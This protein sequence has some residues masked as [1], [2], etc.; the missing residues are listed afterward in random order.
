MATSSTSHHLHA[1]SLTVKSPDVGT[2]SLDNFY[3]VEKFEARCRAYAIQFF[4][5]GIAKADAVDMLQ[6]GA[7]AMGL[8]DRRGQDTIQA[9]MASVFAK[10]PPRPLPS[11]P[12]DYTGLDRTFALACQRADTKHALKGERPKLGWLRR[13]LD[14]DVTFDQVYRAVNRR[15][16]A[17]PST[18][19]AVAYALRTHGETAL[20][21][22]STQ[23]RLAEFSL[24]QIDEL[25]ARLDRARASEGEPAKITDDLLLKL[26]ELLS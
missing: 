1:S 3:P 22:E 19:E 18:I 9:I 21:E 11:D 23:A 15:D 8:V 14:D 26:G 7:S 24:S 25:I 20:S 13:L 10:P 12:D 6:R 2:P 16:D 17:D 5:G 4:M